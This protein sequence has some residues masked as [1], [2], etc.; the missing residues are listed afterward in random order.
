V[1]RI[2]SKP[3]NFFRSARCVSY[4][5]CF[6]CWFCSDLSTGPIE[7]DPLNPPS[8]PLGFGMTHNFLFSFV[9]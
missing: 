7:P 5:T 4:L 2:K 9:S 3:Q 8:L 6:C 1:G